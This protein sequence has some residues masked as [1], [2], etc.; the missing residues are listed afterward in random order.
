MS[1]FLI[2]MSNTL[3]LTCE[4]IQ[5]SRLILSFFKKEIIISVNT[6][7]ILANKKK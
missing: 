5:E 6:P 1:A 7:N 4:I 2:I 3:A